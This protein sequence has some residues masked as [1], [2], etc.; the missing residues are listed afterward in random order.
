MSS[1]VEIANIALLRCGQ[2]LTISALDEGSAEAD[3][4]NQLFGHARD[5]LLEALP[6]G[7]G[8]AKR[9][10]VLTLL[11]N[12]SVS[13][14]KYAYSIPAGCLRPL[15]IWSGN[16]MPAPDE[17]I[18]FELE[19]DS[20]ETDN[21]GVILLTSMASAELVYTW[22]QT[23]TGLWSPSF[24]DAV[25][26]RL[27]YEL[28]F[29]LPERASLAVKLLGYYE[30]AYNKAASIELQKRQEDTLPEAEHIRGR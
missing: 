22:R 13:G 19:N 25:A 5:V 14:W 1:A 6:H 9:R 10:A 24:A 18:P 21:A 8:F 23:N 20:A 12:V 26:W 3:A 7:W 29:A 15:Y 4:C 27:A 11:T 30:A 28:C 17:R 2:R 16:L